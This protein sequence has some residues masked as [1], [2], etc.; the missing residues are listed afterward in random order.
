[1]SRCA[2]NSRR[3]NELKAKA[4]QLAALLRSEMQLNDNHPLNVLQVLEAKGVQ[5]L[6]RPM[7]DGSSGMAIR[8]GNEEDKLLFMMVN[9]N[10]ALGHQRFTSCHEFYHLF[11]QE[12]FSC[13]REKTSMFDDSNE[14][15]YVAD[16]F[17]SYLIL[18]KAALD[19]SVPVLEQRMNAIRLATLLKIEQHYKCS[20]KN[21]LFRLKDNGWIDSDMFDLYSVS[22]KKGALSYGYSTALY[23]ETGTSYFVGDYNRKARKLFE[24]GV[25]SQS[26][27][28]S[29][30]R[31][32]GIEA[33]KAVEE[34]GEV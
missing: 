1:M 13:I 10:K 24:E 26:K 31:D 15:E 20:R 23:D 9:T 12:D 30:L 32:I 2:M 28:F 18:P 11:Y 27:Y 33:D 22:V 3:K 4:A 8:V 17:A 6:F 5:A 14:E 25:I 21:L 7:K 16:W 19:I 34:D 29:L